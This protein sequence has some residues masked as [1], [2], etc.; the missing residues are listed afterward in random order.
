[1]IVAL[2]DRETIV[3][4]R[5]RT[6]ASSSGATKLSIL[7]VLQF[8]S[9]TMRSGVVVSEAPSST[10]AMLFLRGAPAVIRGLVNPATV[11]E[12]FDEACISEQF[13]TWCSVQMC[14]AWQCA[15]CVYSVC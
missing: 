7:K 8:S 10:V 3:L 6:A 14:N 11:P 9:Q 12:D 5:Q 4:P 15:C 1:M 2:Q 13:D